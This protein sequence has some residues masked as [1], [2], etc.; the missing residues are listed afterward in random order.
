MRT[1]ETYVRV[2]A[3]YRGRLGVEVGVFVA[4]DHLRRAGVLSPDQEAEYLDVDDWF[5]A[6][7]PNPGFY[8]D[9]NTVGAVTWFRTPVPAAMQ[10]RVDRMCA[11]LAAHGVAHDVV[12]STD[13]GTRVY[14]DA[15]QVGVVPHVRHEPTPL[16]EGVVLAPTT[17]GSKRSVAASPIRHVMFD[18]DDVLQ[19]VPGGWEALVEPFA[20]DRAPELWTRAVAVERP[21]LAGDGDFLP[22]LAA[23]LA[24]FGVPAPVEEVF[25]AVCCRIDPVAASFAVVDALRRNG[26]GVHLGTN[27][28]RHRAAYMRDGLGYDALFDVSCYSHD[29]GAAKPDP[30]FFVEAARRIGAD[31]SAILF[32]DDR[33]DNVAGARAAGLAAVCWTVDDGHAALLDLLAG[34]GVDGGRT[35]ATA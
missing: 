11:I 1:E 8:A 18:A 5:T 15:F 24:E 10:E 13:P 17:A 7:L 32:V 25:E 9:G 22:L 4:V 2:Q 3:T 27:Q 12:R 6:H 20:G 31:P 30:A 29:L 34:H 23:V 35:V 28:D 33:Q 19:V 21:T 16:P 14:E 26:Y